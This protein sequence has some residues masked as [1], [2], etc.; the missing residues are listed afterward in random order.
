[1]KTGEMYGRMTVQDGDNCHMSHRKFYEWVKLRTKYIEKKGDY[2]DSVSLY[3][4]TGRPTGLP[5]FLF[6]V[7]VYGN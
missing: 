2:V 5:A 3:S 4:H 1:V 7:G 6:W